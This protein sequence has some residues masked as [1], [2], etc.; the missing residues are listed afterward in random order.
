[1]EL[2]PALLPPGRD[3]RLDGVR[4]GRPNRG[5]NGPVGVPRQLD[6]AVEIAFF[7]PAR[8]EIDEGGSRDFRLGRRDLDRDPPEPA[9]R[10]TLF[11]LSKKPSSSR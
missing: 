7:E 3:V 10:K 6:R 8:E 9:Q 2:P 5:R 4:E 1:V 11:S